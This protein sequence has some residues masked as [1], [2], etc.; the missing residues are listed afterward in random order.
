LASGDDIIDGMSIKLSKTKNGRNWEI[1]LT[2]PAFQKESNCYMEDKDLREV[3][4]IAGMVDD[5]DFGFC[6]VI[7]MSYAGKGDQYTSIFLDLSMFM[8]QKEFE[9]MC[10]DNGMDVVYYHKPP[11][12]NEED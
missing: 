11:K 12:Y 7:N 9:K 8:E 1:R 4:N 5:H 6:K 2:I 10:E 3:D